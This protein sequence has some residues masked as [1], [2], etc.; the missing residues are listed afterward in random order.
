MTAGTLIPAAAPGY[1]SKAKMDIQNQ[2]RGVPTVVQ[3]DQQY[4]GSAGM[5]V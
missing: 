1:K 5:Q 2:Q 3:W 4:L